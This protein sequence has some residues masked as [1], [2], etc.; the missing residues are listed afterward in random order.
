MNKSE[1][2]APVVSDVLQ[3]DHH[4]NMSE[5]EIAKAKAHHARKHGEINPQSTAGNPQ[6]EK[7]VPVKPR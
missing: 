1:T 6:Q 4:V 7:K 3:S 2:N 5:A